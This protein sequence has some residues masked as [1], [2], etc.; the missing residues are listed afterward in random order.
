MKNLLIKL[1][2]FIEIF[3][4]ED[5]DTQIELLKRLRKIPGVEIVIEERG[6]KDVKSLY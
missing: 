5:D 2:H 3:E 4:E 6:G 1:I